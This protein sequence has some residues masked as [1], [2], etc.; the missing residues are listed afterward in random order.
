M[1][2]NA[3]VS[4]YTK[5][6]LLST[7]Q[8][9]LEELPVRDVVSWNALLAGFAENG[10]GEE[11]LNCLENMRNEGLVPNPVT[12]LCVLS[13]CNRSGR[14]CESRRLFADMATEYGI[15]PALE[16]YTCMAVALGDVDNVVS[17]SLSSIGGMLSP[18][19][20]FAVWLALLSACKK[21]GDVKR[22]RSAFHRAVQ[23]DGSCST[24][25]VLMAHISCCN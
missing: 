14:L 18:C 3:L 1:L 15:S 2:G 9:L 12:F 25:Y 24:S 17:S 7:A 21:C 22:G 11:A 13:A 10:L 20:S 8:K 5:C 23:L 16:H 4:L 6:G 19:D